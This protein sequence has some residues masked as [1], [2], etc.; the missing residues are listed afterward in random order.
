LVLARE[1][2]AAGAIVVTGAAGRSLKSQMRQA[3]AVGARYAIVLGEK[4]LASGE[5]ALRD[6]AGGSQA[7][8]TIAE[9]LR[10][11]RSQG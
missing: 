10:R 7:S 4:E 1:L 2:R 9:A 8:V 6:L 3:N 11:I 5:L